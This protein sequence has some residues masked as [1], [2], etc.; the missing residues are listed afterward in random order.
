MNTRT[1]ATLALVTMTLAACKK[2]DPA[3]PSTPPTPTTGTVRLSLEFVNGMTPFDINAAYTDGA[4]NNIRF[5]TLKFYMS[6]VVLKDDN[7][8][9]VAS[10]PSTYMLA[11]AAQSDM[12]TFT[13]GTMAAGHIH[14]MHFVL[15]LDETTNRAD[16]T[17]AEYPLNIPGMHWSWNPTAGYK[18]LNM[19]G[20]VDTNNNGTFEDGVD[21][22]FQ[23]HCAQNVSQA[24]SS[25]VLRESHIMAHGDVV[26]GQTVTLEAM[27][28]IADLLT[29]VDLAATPVAM[30][31][32]AGNQLLMNNL[33]TAIHTH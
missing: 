26:A 15:G 4:G 28:D 32:G 24:A 31:N 25:P 19:E 6:G 27:V 33:V 30:G 22:S 5:T 8:V 9:T 21:V 7:D 13:L 20:Y 11:D 18:F 12:N 3:P 14:E 17:Q 1:L 16:P 23:Y 2:D 10:Y 29:T